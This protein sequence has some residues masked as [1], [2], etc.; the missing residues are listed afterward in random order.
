M[1]DDTPP[2]AKNTDSFCVNNS[3]LSLKMTYILTYVGIRC[4]GSVN[5]VIISY[6][7]TRQ[8]N[9]SL[10]IYQ[11]RRPTDFTGMILLMTKVND[12]L[13]RI[14]M[15]AKYLKCKKEL[16]SNNHMAWVS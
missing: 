1:V 14:V 10:N 7:S 4:S 13:P 15:M 8:C 3:R 6:L 5:I 2:T 12:L 16:E 11:V 9:I